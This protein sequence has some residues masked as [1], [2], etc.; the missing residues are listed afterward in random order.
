MKAR[1]MVD[2]ARA[3]W[4]FLVHDIWDI[5]LSGLRGIHRNMI[6]FLRAVSLM[7]HGFRDDECQLHASS[8]TYSSLMAIVPVL[9]LSLALARVF[10]GAELA[11]DQLQEWIRSQFGGSAIL[12]PANTTRPALQTASNTVASATTTTWS[13][14]NG[15]AGQDGTNVFAGER[16]ALESG[17]ES[18]ADTEETVLDLGLKLEQLVDTAFESIAQINFTKL[19]G[20]G[21]VLLIWMVISVLGR[22]ESSFN[23]VWGVSEGRHLWRKFTDYLSVLLILP[24]LVIAASSIPAAEM[25]TR[26]AIGDSKETVQ[27]LLETPLLKQ[28][29]VLML[30][31]L[32]FMFIIRFMPNTFVNVLPGLTGG[33]VTAVLFTLW[34]KLCAMFQVGVARSSAL[35]G[36]FAIVPILLA[37]VYVSW[38]IVLFGAEVAFAFQNC[39]TYRM[40]QGARDASVHAR[41]MLAVALV[42]EIVRTMRHSSSLFCSREFAREKRVSV[43]LL[44]DVMAELVRAGIVA[45]VAGHPACYVLQRDSATLTA[46]DVVNAMLTAGVSPA[47]LGLNHLDE[48][49]RDLGG[50]WCK[51]IERA[52]PQSVGDLADG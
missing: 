14:T 35:Y 34:L 24:F 3:L 40:E 9:A 29:A 37:W 42:A 12:V 31:S 52:L 25:V 39:D 17:D 8:L 13:A 7:W 4:T 11:Q 6:K 33:V 16:E 21:L 1:G 50:A 27:T 44:N 18:G 32:V 2:R 41:V 15:V 48:R 47:K 43:R 23:R 5:E 51:N 45:E 28:F 20:I 19:G 49:V 46:G 30:T 36:S 10:G 22:V 38:E 26:L